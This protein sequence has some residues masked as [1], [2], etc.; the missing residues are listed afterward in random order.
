MACGS[1]GFFRFVV[2]ACGEW[3][4]DGVWGSPVEEGGG[5][6]HRAS[7]VAAL[8]VALSVR[9]PCFASCFVAA[10]CDWY[11]VV[12]GEG[13]VVVDGEGHVDGVPAEP[14]DGQRGVVFE[15]AA[16]SGDTAT[17]CGGALACWHWSV[18][19]VVVGEAV[20]GKGLVCH[21]D[22]PGFDHHGDGFVRVFVVGPF[23]DESH[24]SVLS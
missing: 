22:E 21:G 24:V 10:A 17:P 13:P 5:V 1:H 3:W 12:E 19:L 11:D 14:A 4:G 23:F 9:W 18:V 20:E 7:S 15:A 2:V 8:R 16:F 6:L